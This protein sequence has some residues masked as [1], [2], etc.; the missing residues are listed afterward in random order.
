MKEKINLDMPEVQPREQRLGTIIAWD[1]DIDELHRQSDFLGRASGCDRK[2]ACK[3]CE[4]RGPFSQ[5]SVCSEQ[6]VECQAGNV[7]DAVLIQHAPIGCGAGQ[8]P[9][10]SIYRNGLAMRGHKVENIRIINTN[11][12]ED[13]VVFGAADKLRTAIDDAW[14]RYKPKAI[15]IATSC[16]TGIIG[17]D[18]DSIAKEKQEE[19]NIPVIP[20][21]CEGFRSKHWSTGFD[22]T[23]H[24]ILRQIVNKHPHKQEDLVNVINL[25]GSD[26]FTPMLANLNLRVNYVVDLA[27]VDDLA[28]M[29]EAAA[30]VGFCYT[31]SS[32]LAAALEKHF[33]VPE[34]KAPMPYGFAGTDAWLRELARVTHREELAEKYIKAEHARVRPRIAELKKKL[35]GIKG[36][37]ATG[38]AYSH[39]LIQVLRELE[40][41]V[42]GSL[43]F[44]HDP[45]YDS[46][47]ER[48]D[49]LGHLLKHYGNVENFHV[50]NR[51]QYQLY[52]FLQKVHPDFM[53]IRHN[54]LAPLASRLGIPAAPLGDEHIAIGYQGIINLGET[55]LDILARKKYHD[56][57]KKHVTLPYTDWWLKQEDAY[58]L[59]R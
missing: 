55:I 49:S 3:L 50:S 42:N 56:S 45:V 20:M 32:Y 27:S 25:W 48:E 4:L 15:F 54:G 41:E 34:V 38:S 37:V 8:V 52:A 9:Y 2:A 5:G 28:R 23:Q 7:R 58:I 26:V 35:K 17:E 36:Y 16:A 57:I 39:G 51:Q 19:L 24:G 10:N 47:D 33:G 43:V 30:T 59:A 31:L 46:G 12:G 14:T 53:L 11:L 29:S 13:D 44:H 6:M 18:V 40:V 1:G 22:A 21:A